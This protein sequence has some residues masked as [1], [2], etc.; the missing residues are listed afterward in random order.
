[1]TYNYLLAGIVLGILKFYF[2]G[3][4]SFQESGL[5]DPTKILSRSDRTYIR[6]VLYI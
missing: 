5:L 2:P 6:E 4:T 3:G 1:M